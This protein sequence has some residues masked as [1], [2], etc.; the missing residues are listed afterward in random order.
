MN[1]MEQYS[2]IP[3]DF[4][5]LD[6]LIAKEILK[7]KKKKI[8]VINQKRFDKLED[9]I[10]VKFNIDINHPANEDVEEKLL[11]ALE[12]SGIKKDNIK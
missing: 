4:L 9:K 11:F 3:I 8:K 12:R 6:C 10:C 1:E 5:A 2:F 7:L